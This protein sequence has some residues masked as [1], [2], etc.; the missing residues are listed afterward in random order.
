MNNQGV[1]KTTGI[2][3]KLD[4]ILGEYRKNNKVIISSEQNK[5]IW[6]QHLEEKHLK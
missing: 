1:T 6:H 3:T 2:G 4:Q 5:A